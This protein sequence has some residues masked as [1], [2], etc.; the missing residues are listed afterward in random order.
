MSFIGQGRGYVATILVQMELRVGIILL[1]EVITEE[2]DVDERKCCESWVLQL[3]DILGWIDPTAGDK[4]RVFEDEHKKNC[5][6][7]NNYK[8]SKRRTQK[9]YT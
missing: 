1:Q 5:L 2:S 6:S 9:H 7:A 4:F 8:E 3:S